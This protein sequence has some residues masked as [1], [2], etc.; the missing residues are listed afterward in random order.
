MATMAT[1]TPF[2]AVLFDFNGVLW[3]DTQLQ[4]RAWV[5]FS[6]M[7]RGAPLTPEELKIH[8]F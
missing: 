8:W 5:E 4:E 2:Q 3:W 7:V 6:S 1:G